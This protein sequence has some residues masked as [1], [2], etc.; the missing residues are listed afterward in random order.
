MEAHLPYD[1]P[2]E[3]R[4][5]PDEESPHF[6]SVKA[7]LRERRPIRTGSGL[8]T[9]MP[10]G[11][12]RTYIA[13]S[14]A[15]S[16]PS[17]STSTL[18]DHGEALGEYGAWQHGGGL[19]PPVTKIPLV[20]ERGPNP[21]DRTPNADGVG[22]RRE[23]PRE[24]ARHRHATV[25]RPRPSSPTTAAAFRSA[26]ALERPN[27]DGAPDERALEYHGIS[28]RRPLAPRRRLRHRACR[29]RERHNGIA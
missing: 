15:N 3:Y 18:A 9:T 2:D 10:F 12:C 11:T 22:E 25:F 20:V 16:P 17:S 26:A 19:H 13:T 6:D 28:K 4:T 23:T 14:T 27:R 21:D 8:R 29:P 1:P 7:T 24:S 5:Y